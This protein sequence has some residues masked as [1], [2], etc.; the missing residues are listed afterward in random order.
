MNKPA[1]KLEGKLMMNT[2]RGDILCGGENKGGQREAEK[3]GDP[4]NQ[5]FQMGAAHQEEAVA[6][7]A[8]VTI[9]DELEKSPSNK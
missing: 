9:Y 8:I 6:M 7:P 1:G 5:T 2:N 3:G 4:R